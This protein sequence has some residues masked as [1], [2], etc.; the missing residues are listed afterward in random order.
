MSQEQIQARVLGNMRSLMGRLRYGNGKPAKFSPLTSGF[1]DCSGTIHWCYA[2]EGITIGGMSYDQAVEGVEIASGRTVDQFIRI[3]H[4]LEPA[5]IIAMGLRAG[6]GGGSRINHVELS[7]GPGVITLGHGSGIGPGRHVV[8]ASWLLGDATHW[9]VRRITTK[10]KAEK[11]KEKV[12][13]LTKTQAK[14]LT[15]VNAKT[16]QMNYAVSKIVLPAL[17]RLDTAR[18]SEAKSLAEINGKVDALGKAVEQISGGKI[19]MK[20]ITAA[21]EKGAREGAA[22]VAAEDVASLLEVTPKGDK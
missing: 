11:L 10:S 18:I 4:L 13:S 20:A 16:D 14:A 7:E 19:D 22:S 9:T 21:A 6:Y 17:S 5:D 1:S 12:M 8:T 2:Q 15:T 3:S